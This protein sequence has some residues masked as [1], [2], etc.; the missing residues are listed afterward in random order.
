[1]LFASANVCFENAFFA[2]IILVLKSRPEEQKV[3]SNR[4]KEETQVAQIQ[5][6]S[7][8]VFD[9]PR[10]KFPFREN[11]NKIQS[12]KL[13]SQLKAIS[14]IVFKDRRQDGREGGPNARNK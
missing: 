12:E 11:F 4:S 7:S 14:Q 1:M 13:K 3:Q 9:L 5:L 8:A 6:I 10:K 2:S